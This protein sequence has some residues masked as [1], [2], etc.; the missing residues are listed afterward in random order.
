MV[1]AVAPDLEQEEW[2]AFFQGFIRIFVR[3]CLLHRPQISFPRGFIGLLENASQ[4]ITCLSAAET[5]V[6]RMLLSAP[7]PG[8]GGGFP[9][10]SR[11][12]FNFTRWIA[13]ARVRDVF[14][15][16]TSLS[17][18]ALLLCTWAHGSHIS[19][20]RQASARTLARTHAR[21]RPHPPTRPPCCSK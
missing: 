20:I 11:Y 6:T 19:L 4:D 18:N 16:S 2:N 14:F 3:F 1:Q 5:L 12:W 9:P 17:C 10:E 8:W 21:T 15:V 7:R 13:A